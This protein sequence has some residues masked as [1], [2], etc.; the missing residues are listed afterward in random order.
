MNVLY[1][2]D[3]IGAG[4]FAISGTLSALHKQNDYDVFTFSAL[5]S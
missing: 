4:V 3:L 1:L 2:T 5:G